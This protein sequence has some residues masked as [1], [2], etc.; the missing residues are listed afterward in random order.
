VADTAFAS[1]YEKQQAIDAQVARLNAQ[2]KVVD[3]ADLASNQAYSAR[4]TARNEVNAARTEILTAS[5]A[6]RPALET[7]IQQLQQAYNQANDEY[8]RASDVRNEAQDKY[9][10]IDDALT[11]TQD[12]IVD[13]R[14]DPEVV[15]IAA[16]E[17]NYEDAEEEELDDEEQT[18]LDDTAEDGD[19]EDAEPELLN[20]ED[21]ETA[22]NRAAL[23]DWNDTAPGQ[24]VSATDKPF[25]ATS[26]TTNTT[27]GTKTTV[28][29]NSQVPKYTPRDNP[30]HKYATYTYSIALFIL[31]RQ[32]INLLTTNPGEWKPN[33]GRVKSCL[34]ASGGR[35]SG[36]YARN[37]NFTDDFY[38]DNLKMTTVIGM[39]SRSKSTN[40]IDIGFTVLEPYGMSLLD[41]IIEA[42]NDVQAPNFKAMPYLLEVEFYGY[43]DDGTQILIE[44]QRK[45]FPIQIIEMKIKVGS[46]GA[47]YAIKA[48]PW[49]H[50]ALSQSAATT[51][52]NLEVKASTVGEFFKNNIE[53]DQIAVI[54]QDEAKTAARSAN[55]RKEADLKAA[56]QAERKSRQETADQ[57]SRDQGVSEQEIADYKVSQSARK[58]ED[59]NELSKNQGIVNRAFAVA[60]YCGGVNAW[61]TDLVLKKLRGTKDGILFDIHPDIAKTKIVVPEQKDISRSAVKD[62]KPGDAANAAA[63][64][65]NRVFTDA[66]AFP[67]SAGTGIPAVIDMIMRN[68]EYITKQVKDP[69]KMTPQD[70]AEKEGKPL[71]WYKVIPTV[72]V[73]EY[74]FALNKF[75]TETTYHIMPYIVYD[76][77]HPQ[78]PTTP[79]QGAMK[80]YY[81]SYTG[82]NTDILDFQIDFDTLFYTAVTAGAAKWQADIATKAD[83]QKDSAQKAA[84][85]DPV[86]AKELVNRQLRLIP[87]QPTTG[88][89]GAK[90][91]VKQVAATD[92]QASQYSNS[93]GDMLNL[94]LKI[95][96]DPELI[97]Q[98]DIYTNPSQGG[99]DTQ[100]N[101]LGI[102]QDNGS[103]PMDNGEVMA[104][105]EFR[106]ILDMDDTTGNPAKD[107]KYEANSVFSGV[108]RI[109]T[110]DNIFQGGKFEQTIDL[111]RMPDAVNNATI[112]AG[113]GQPVSPPTQNNN[114]TA[115]PN[116]RTLA[117]GTPAEVDNYNP[118]DVDANKEDEELIPL[119][120]DEEEQPD[121][122]ETVDESDEDADYQDLHAIDEDAE[123]VDID[124]FKDSESTDPAAGIV[125][126]N[127]TFVDT[128]QPFAPPTQF[129]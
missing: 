50:Q 1:D 20:T 7:Q 116:A 24:T 66:Q 63:K 82:K 67:I 53:A 49:N 17:A 70:I 51:P 129:A 23:G 8:L 87:E 32:D 16:D 34:I 98:D 94:K 68:S 106:T 11:R 88:G 39:N 84:L 122:T 60:S 26:N 18:N 101:T 13:P 10:R 64:D 126:D 85:T 127:D 62:D 37:S 52:I 75:S 28:G 31:S 117:N 9:N 36:Q 74:D 119:N 59:S 111:I 44:D 22:A 78:G 93:R 115:D 58:L 95:V 30:L 5:A 107:K 12:R 92:I 104:Q 47:E 71:N 29:A 121:E 110:V 125:N 114:S 72:K 77:K 56:D 80:Q 69:G 128:N 61:Y 124:D 15:A 89:S 79:P 41:R 4:R 112:N 35:N 38:F 45:R 21:D 108:Y 27:A 99:Y 102:M 42:A 57:A 91:D 19:E 40:A 73:G 3:N 83:E 43:N 2:Q 25:N 86:Y 103:I 97:K 81:Y 54:N 109:L 90:A 113:A 33:T 55:Q 6:D 65:A 120:E 118:T 76:S 96:G 46:K 123:E 14:T 48:I 105:V 100:I